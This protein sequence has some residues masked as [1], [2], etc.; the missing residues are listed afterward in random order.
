MTKFADVCLV[1]FCTIVTSLGQLFWKIGAKSLPVIFTNWPLLIGFSF[2]IVAAF[3]L[4]HSFK[5]GE[6]SVLFPMYATNYVWVS[7]LAHY[8]LGESLNS[9]K[10]YGMIVIIFGVIVLSKGAHKHTQVV[11]P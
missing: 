9:L 2:H 10:I 1:I 6:V 11:T 4:I 7:I 5:T 8:Y 3:I